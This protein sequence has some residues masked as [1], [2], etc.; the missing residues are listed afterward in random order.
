MI[1]HTSGTTSRPKQVPLTQL[2]LCTS[3]HN[4]SK[5][6]ELNALDRCLNLMPMFHVHG[7]VIT[8]LSS[9]VVAAEVVCIQEFKINQF[10]LWLDQFQPTWYS[11]VSTL[12]LSILQAAP[13]HLD[14][15]Q[16]HRL[17]FIRTSSAPI[18]PQAILDLEALF[19]VPVIQGYGMT[20]ASP[21]MAINPLPPGQRKPE[22]VG[23]ACG[24]KISI[25]D[26]HHRF[27][28]PYEV[29]EVVISNVHFDGYLGDPAITE[30]AFYEGWFRT[31]DLGYLDEDGY[32]FLK[33]RKKEI[34]NRGG[35]KIMPL[36][37]DYVALKLPEI[38]QAVTFAVPHP[39]LGEDAVM[40]VVLQEGKTISPQAIRAFLFQNL[41][42][43]KVPTRVIIVN[44]IPKGA[45]KK[46]Q[47][48]GLAEKLA[49]QLQ[50]SAVAPT[51]AIETTLATL[52]QQVLDLTTVGI[53]DNFFGLGGYSL[54][55]AD[56]VAL[57]EEE[58]GLSLGIGIIFE[59]PTIAEL[60]AVLDSAK[61]WN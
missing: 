23:I 25:L 48:I 2:N 56:L 18:P 15:I 36:E 16:N 52:W 40:A 10:W 13:K 43:F 57:I 24:V 51:T 7:L 60:A 59:Y 31:G 9:L 11:G 14:V 22:S 42:D 38:Y 49:A 1:L 58:F 53:N 8:L 44:E 41:V 39:V 45:T 20:E 33:G 29:G 21:Q 30:A 5:F 54:L 3:A 28:S 47:R 26:E 35:E 37:V 34:I 46:L 6:L 27:L 4:I 17:R 19:K 61:T 50:V 12:H 55:A 32:L